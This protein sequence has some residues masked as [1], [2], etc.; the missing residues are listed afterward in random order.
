MS[1]PRSWLAGAMLVTR[2]SLSSVSELEIEVLLRQPYQT[3]QVH[4]LDRSRNT[5]TQSLMELVPLGLSCEQLPGSFRN[6]IDELF[7]SLSQFRSQLRTGMS[8]AV[9]EKAA[10]LGLKATGGGEHELQLETSLKRLRRFQWSLLLLM[11]Q[12]DLHRRFYCLVE[13]YRLLRPGHEDVLV[14]LLLEMLS[15]RDGPFLTEEL[16]NHE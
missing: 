11:N 3:I 7:G 16:G 9:P 6:R 15:G 2:K 10:Y 13:R 1:I 8:E 4:Y 14:D 12:K 5:V